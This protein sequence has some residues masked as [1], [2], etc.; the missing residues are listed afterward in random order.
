MAAEPAVVAGEI[1][2]VC[3]C[4][5]GTVVFKCSLSRQVAT[6][7]LFEPVLGRLTLSSTFDKRTSA[8]SPEDISDVNSA[9]V[10][11]PYQSKYAPPDGCHCPASGVLRWSIAGQP[12]FVADWRKM[13][14][15]FA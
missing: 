4:N 10:V 11:A 7:R 3:D 1:D 9:S 6:T 14:L 2:G 13:V 15:A 8:L 12:R 5:R